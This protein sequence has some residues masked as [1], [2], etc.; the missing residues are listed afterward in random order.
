[1]IVTL[2]D[3][4]CYKS[5]KERGTDERFWTFFHQDWYQLVLYQKTTPVVKQQ[6]VH[7]DYMKNKKDMHFNRILEACEF[8]GN[9]HI[10]SFRYNWNHEVNAEFY[11]TLHVDDQ[12]SKVHH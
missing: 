2:R 7:I 9:S 1:V 6:W 3:K 5:T 4:P 11:T 8:H 12:W 10:L